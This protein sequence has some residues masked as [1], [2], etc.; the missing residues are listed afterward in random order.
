MRVWRKGNALGS[1]GAFEPNEWADSA[2]KETE[3]QKKNRY[4][5]TEFKKKNYLCIAE[6]TFGMSN[7]QV[8][9]GNRLGR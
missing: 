9:V 6:A 2:K 7:L 8:C 4:E 5:S 3:F 1:Y